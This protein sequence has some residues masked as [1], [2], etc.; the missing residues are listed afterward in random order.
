MKYTYEEFKNYVR[1]NIGKHLSEEY[2][3]AKMEFQEIK[4]SG[5]EVYEALMISVNNGESMKVIPALNLTQA[6][7]QYS[8]GA[9]I[10]NIVRD[11]ADIR[12]NA[13][14]PEENLGKQL[15]DYEVMKPK[16]FPR[17]VN[18]AANAQY[19]SDKPHIRV[20]DLSL[21]FA[22]RVQEDQK[23]MAE[24]IIDDQLAEMWGVDA[25]QLRDVAMENMSTREPYF[26][27]IEE[28]IFGMKGSNPTGNIFSR[29]EDVD[30]KSFDIPFF[31]LT[32]AQKCKG[33]VMA[34]DPKTMSKIS[35]KLGAVYIL[36]SSVDEVLIVP[37]D[38]MEDVGQL[39]KMVSQVNDEAVNPH[40]R[41]SNHVYEYDSEH[42]TLVMAGD[43]QQ[44]EIQTM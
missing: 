11:L 12:M 30:L 3:D 22:V 29:L 42:Q 14:L 16:I 36:P 31:I 6:F 21:M 9:N 8:Q 32:N 24:A 25:A 34:M 27:N 10:D 2:E 28:E 13:K 38:V 26:A 17:L 35:E 4:K 43:P 18:S 39:A 40:D 7:H 33:A 23:G 1:N 20:A 5:G 15:L 19:L 44:G 41:L 37:R